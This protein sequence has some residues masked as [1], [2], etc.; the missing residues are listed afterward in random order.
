M[1]LRISAPTVYR[2]VRSK[3][4]HAVKVG[5]QLRIHADD[6]DKLLHRESEEPA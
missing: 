6:V 3:E 4:L 1:Q 5:G 2:M